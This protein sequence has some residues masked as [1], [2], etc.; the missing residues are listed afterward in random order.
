MYR[1]HHRPS[2]SPLIPHFPTA[3]IPPQLHLN[4]APLGGI[5]GR[6]EG[7]IERE[8]T[9][10]ASG[11]CL[12][13]DRNHD[14]LIK[15]RFKI[16]GKAMDGRAGGRGETEGAIACVVDP[17]LHVGVEEGKAGLG[18]GE[19][20]EVVEFDDVGGFHV[21]EVFV[22]V[23]FVP[24]FGRGDGREVGGIGVRDGDARVFLEEFL[25][26]VEAFGGELVV[27]ERAQ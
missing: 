13:D 15:H 19:L 22:G 23:D 20:A 8:P 12:G 16:T 17:F 3:H 26:A 11:K 10:H 6:P 2:Q 24:E 5:D 25:R 18:L 7:E 14:I 21:L 4:S 1:G 9:K 27:A